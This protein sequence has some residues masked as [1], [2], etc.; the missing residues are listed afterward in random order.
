MSRSFIPYDINACPANRPFNIRKK[1]QYAKPIDHRIRIRSQNPSALSGLTTFIKDDGKGNMTAPTKAIPKTPEIKTKKKILVLSRQNFC[2]SVFQKITCIDSSTQT[3][4]EH[5]FCGSQTE[6]HV[7]ANA[8]TQS[9]SKLLTIDH[10]ELFDLPPIKKSV[11]IE[12]TNQF[13]LPDNILK[14]EGMVT[15]L[16]HEDIQVDCCVRLCDSEC[17]TTNILFVNDSQKTPSTYKCELYK[18]QNLVSD[19]HDDV[20]FLLYSIN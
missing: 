10:S 18:P 3:S 12:S 14:D 6:N 19:S 8:N 4:V 20:L 11:R 5:T 1:P 2:V 13:S 9:E 7:Y 16:E 15:Y 17:Q